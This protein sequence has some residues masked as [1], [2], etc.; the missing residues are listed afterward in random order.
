MGSATCLQAFAGDW[1]GSEGFHHP[2]AGCRKLSG[3]NS[4]FSRNGMATLGGLWYLS[5]GCPFLWWCAHVVAAAD[6]YSSG[7]T[8]NLIVYRIPTIAWRLQLGSAFIPAVPLIVGI[9]FVPGTLGRILC[10][11]HRG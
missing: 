1:N 11:R 7:F 10:V 9:Y 4:R 3:F 8:S 6:E 2:S 5:V